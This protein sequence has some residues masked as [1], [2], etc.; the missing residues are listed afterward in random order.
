MTSRLQLLWNTFRCSGSSG[1]LQHPTHYMIHLWLHQVFS[2]QHISNLVSSPFKMYSY[3]NPFTTADATLVQMIQVT[4]IYYYILLPSVLL[5]SFLRLC[6]LSILEQKPE[7]YH[8]LQVPAWSAPSAPH[9]SM[10]SSLPTLIAH[11]ALDPLAS[12]PFFEL[13]WPISALVL[14]PCSF[15]FLEAY[16]HTGPWPAPLLHLFKG[17]CLVSVYWLP[18]VIFWLL[19][20]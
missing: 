7:S 9:P 13:T 20:P 17:S 16:L 5:Q 15:M 3:F 10:T 8:H 6:S 14:C 11:F 12:L 2:V 19:S 1:P 18:S 4:I